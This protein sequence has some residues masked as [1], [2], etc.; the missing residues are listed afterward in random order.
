MGIQEFFVLFAQFCHKPK[1]A[2]GSKGYFFFKKDHKPYDPPIPLLGIY[3]E[4]TRI[5]KDAS[6]LMFIAVL[7]TIARMWKQP[8][9]DRQM[10]KEDIVHVYNGKLLSHEKK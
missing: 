10:A 3:F 5:L 9:C 6:S 4:K 2:I 7:F 8:Q 1:T